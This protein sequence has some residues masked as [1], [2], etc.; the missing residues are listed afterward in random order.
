MEGRSIRR[1][2]MGTARRPRTAARAGGAPMRLREGGTASAVRV[3]LLGG[4][5]ISLGG[6]SVGEDGWRLRKAKSLVKLL[7]P[8][9]GHRMHRDRAMER[10]LPGLAPEVAA[11]TT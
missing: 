1:A 11:N 9:R 8:A 10:P 3:R 7:A 6:R 4:F 2:N 5:S